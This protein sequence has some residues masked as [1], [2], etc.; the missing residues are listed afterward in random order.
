MCEARRGLCCALN[1]LSEDYQQSGC[2]EPPLSPPFFIEE[3]REDMVLSCPNSK[4][5]Y[6]C[7]LNYPLCEG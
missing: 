2:P 1:M 3:E 5:K 6:K 4:D 7:F